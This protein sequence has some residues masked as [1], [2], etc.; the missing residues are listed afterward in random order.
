MPRFQKDYGNRALIFIRSINSNV[1]S[2]GY[3]PKEQWVAAVIVAETTGIVAST[4]RIILPAASMV[5]PWAS[6]RPTSDEVITVF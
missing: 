2:L 6:E 4:V 1:A 5:Q 3:R